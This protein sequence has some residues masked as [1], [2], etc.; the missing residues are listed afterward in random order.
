MVVRLTKMVILNEQI[1]LMYNLKDGVIEET[2]KGNKDTNKIK[3][4]KVKC[5][6]Q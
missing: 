2:E 1:H 5:F 3:M 6:I 4:K